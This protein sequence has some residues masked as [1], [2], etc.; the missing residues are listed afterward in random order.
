MKFLTQ[1]FDRKTVRLNVDRKSRTHQNSI[2]APDF[3]QGTDSL[4]LCKPSGTTIGSN[5]WAK[6]MGKQRYAPYGIT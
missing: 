6:S 3:K 2:Y 5:T 4:D 1:K